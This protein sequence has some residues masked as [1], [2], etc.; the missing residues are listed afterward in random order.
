M[1]AVEFPFRSLGLENWRDEQPELRGSDVQL[2]RSWHVACKVALL[3]V[4]VNCWYASCDM[5]RSTTQGAWSRP[6]LSIVDQSSRRRRCCDQESIVHPCT[7]NLPSADWCGWRTFGCTLCASCPAW[8]RRRR[9]TSRAR[10]PPRVPGADL[11]SCSD[12]RFSGFL[13]PRVT[14]PRVLLRRWFLHNRQTCT[15][16][17]A[18]NAFCAAAPERRL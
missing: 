17:L 13:R 3:Q 18:V 12:D 8:S 9:S 4:C 1:D 11:Q 7:P 14:L 15:S 16:G 10:T 2:H 5:S 6:T